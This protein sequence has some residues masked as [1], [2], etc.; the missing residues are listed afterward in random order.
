MEYKIK[1]LAKI[2]GVSVRT[3]RYYD[4]ISLF[5]PSGVLPNGYRYY[6]KPELLRLQQILFYRELDFPLSEIKRILAAKDFNPR[7]A[8]KEHKRLI[9]KKKNRLDTLIKTINKTIKHMD[10]ENQLADQDLYDPFRDPDVKQYQSETKLRWGQSDAYRQSTARV[11]QMSKA[12]M[13]K[14]K[15]DS[16]ALTQKIAD[17]MDQGADHPVVQALIADHFQSIQLFYDCSLEFYQNLGQMYVGDARFAAHYNQF[18]PG[19]A[20]F[21]QEA[22]EIF[23]TQQKQWLSITKQA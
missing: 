12:D 21:M 11:K 7:Q 6:K 19:L 18:R 13:A 20:N 2:A 17:H 9:E 10:Q 16:Q 23:V 22:I 8:L 14:I 5:R 1:Q 3:L 15:A 4:Q